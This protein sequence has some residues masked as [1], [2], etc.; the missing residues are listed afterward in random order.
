MG[1]F[2]PFSQEG[3]KSRQAA[4][5]ATE[6]QR[7]IDVMAG[8]ISKSVAI[9]NPEM[10]RSYFSQISIETVF[11]NAEALVYG[12]FRIRIISRIPSAV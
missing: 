4:A 5:T 3:R 9:G 6:I 11:T 2:G 1:G 7:E 10:R 12:S 8:R